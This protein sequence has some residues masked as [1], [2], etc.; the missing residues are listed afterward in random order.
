ML[1]VEARDLARGFTLD[2]TLL[3]IRALVA[4]D[5]A[6][7]DADLGFQF[8]VLPV[9]LENNE[10]ATFDLT[11]AVK[12]I[13]L[14]AMKEKFAGAFG[15][16]DFVAGF[17]VGLNIGVVEKRFAVFDPRE[18]IIDIRFAPAD[19]LYFAPF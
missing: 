8:A 1:A 4:R 14:L 13:D 16:R 2:G 7:A 19:R 3:Q 12:S 10:R 6:L 5:F 17:F 18:R 15:C 11:F 9:E